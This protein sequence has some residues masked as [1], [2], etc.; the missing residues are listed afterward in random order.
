L[1]QNFGLGSGYLIPVPQGQVIL[2]HY[3]GGFDDFGDFLIREN[4]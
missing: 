2:E 3:Q 1:Q 4:R